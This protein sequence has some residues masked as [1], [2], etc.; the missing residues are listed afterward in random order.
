M[1][2][3]QGTQGKQNFN[4]ITSSYL[5]NQGFFSN[6]TSSVHSAMRTNK[7]MVQGQDILRGAVNQAA[8]NAAG[9]TSSVTG[10][11]LVPPDNLNQLNGVD[12]SR[13]QQDADTLQRLNRRE[14][15]GK[16][17]IQTTATGMAKEGIGNTFAG[18]VDSQGM[19]LTDQGGYFD[20]ATGVN[21]PKATIAEGVTVPDPGPVPRDASSTIGGK[22]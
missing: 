9:A 4:D 12:G 6:T 17:R 2:T 10:D 20:S 13:T 22:R 14:E 1:V 3:N 19:R 16:G 7:A 18:L 21:A 11:S 5:S 8:S 15:A